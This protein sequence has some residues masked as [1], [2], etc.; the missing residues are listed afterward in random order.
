MGRKIDDAEAERLQDAF[1]GVGRSLHR[2][3][4]LALHSPPDNHSE[5]LLKLLLDPSHHD[6]GSC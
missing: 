3:F 6:L 5:A 2:A 4:D 1:T